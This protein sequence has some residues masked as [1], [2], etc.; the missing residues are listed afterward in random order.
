M[1]GCAVLTILPKNKNEN[2]ESSQCSKGRDRMKQRLDRK[3]LGQP[4]SCA[5]A[6]L[7]RVSQYQIVTYLSLYK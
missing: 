7:A 6:A 5:W 3:L 4:L 2:T 1:R